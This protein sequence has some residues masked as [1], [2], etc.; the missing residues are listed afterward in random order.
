MRLLANITKYSC[1]SDD[2]AFYD[3]R[4]LIQVNHPIIARAVVFSLLLLL[5]LLLLHFAFRTILPNRINFRS[6]FGPQ[7]LV[8]WT[9]T[10]SQHPFVNL[11]LLDCHLL[12][13]F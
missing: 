7:Q 11:T 9:T 3:W 13:D 5:L 12:T 6:K 1:Q 10:L 8:T 4:V 2:L